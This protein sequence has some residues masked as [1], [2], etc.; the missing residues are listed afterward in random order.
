MFFPYFNKHIQVPISCHFSTYVNHL[1]NSSQTVFKNFTSSIL[2]LDICIDFL[3]KK[4][5]S[6]TMDN[7]PQFTWRKSISTMEDIYSSLLC[8]VYTHTPRRAQKF[9]IAWEIISAVKNGGIILNNDQKVT[10]FRTN[11]TCY[12]HTLLAMKTQILWGKITTG[13]KHSGKLIQNTICF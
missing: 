1:W 6:H 7:K 12:I 4:Y 11:V 5:L 8:H 10:V 3:N 2:F 13:M 9:F